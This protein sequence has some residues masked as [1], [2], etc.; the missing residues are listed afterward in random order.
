[1]MNEADLVGLTLEQ[2]RRFEELDQNVSNS[3]EAIL[4]WHRLLDRRRLDRKLGAHPIAEFRLGDGP[5]VLKRADHAAA[6]EEG[7]AVEREPFFVRSE[8]EARGLLLRGI[9]YLSDARGEKFAC[10]KGE[11]D[12]DKL[13]TWIAQEIRERGALAYIR[14]HA[15]YIFGIRIAVPDA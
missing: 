15:P 9:G 14:R 3:R 5:G 10:D 2:A 4:A 11:G 1:M 12:R 7:A 6:E 8:E 13:A